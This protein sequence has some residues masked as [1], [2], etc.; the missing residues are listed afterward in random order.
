M[1]HTRYLGYPTGGSHCAGSIISK[2][3]VLTAAHCVEDYESLEL[4]AGSVIKYTQWSKP[5]NDIEPQKR[6][7]AGIY[8]HP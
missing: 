6:R 8:T 3:F 2:S 5:S 4:T 7:S 1:L